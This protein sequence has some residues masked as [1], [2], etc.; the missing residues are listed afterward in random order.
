MSSETTVNE[1]VLPEVRMHL[2][3][4]NE[5]TTARVVKSELCTAGRKAAG[6]VRHIEI[7]VTGTQLV[8]QCHPGQSIGVVPA[9]VTEHGKPHAVR[10]YSLASPSTGEHGNPAIISTT[11]KRTIEEHWETHKLFTGVASN[12]LCD[13][14]EGDEVRLTGPAGKRFLLPAD[15]NAHDYMFFATGTG[16]APFRGM[17]L[18]L[19]ARGCTSKITLLMG[20][21]YRTDLLYH[22]TML[23]LEQKHPNFRYLTAISRERQ[24]DGHDRMYVQ[25]RLTTERDEL[26]PQLA[27][28]R[29]LVYIC[30]VAG[31]ELGIFKQ[32]A[33][34]LSGSTLEQYL[35]VDSEILADI[36]GWDRRMIQR[37]IRPTRRV[38]LEVYA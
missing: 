38:F 23:D 17:V 2:Y 3:R 8:G 32:I 27:S 18:D 16:I 31:M 20:A 34:M 7:D 9:G 15:V 13:L 22:E 14:G 6:V 28:E 35:R 5:P 12:Y 30:G 26:G 10:L 29:N 21:P 11:V 19:M 25:D 33:T 37:Q 1:P 36:N 4:P 24:H